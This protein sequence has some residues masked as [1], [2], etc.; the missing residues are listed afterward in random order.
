MCSSDL[1]M[2][3]GMKSGLSI[4][5]AI[6]LVKNE[7]P[8]PFSQELDY[9]L[10]Q[11]QLGISVEDAFENLAKRIGSEGVTCRTSGMGSRR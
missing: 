2:A 6:G 1:L 11:N 5:Q 9:V 8:N 4:I 7:M 3:N 10:K